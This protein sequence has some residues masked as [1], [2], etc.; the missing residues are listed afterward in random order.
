MDS[1]NM[2]INIFSYQCTISGNK[3]LI[4]YFCQQQKSVN[5]FYFSMLILKLLNISIYENIMQISLKYFM[6]HNV[7]TTF[8]LNNQNQYKYLIKEIF[9]TIDDYIKMFNLNLTNI[10][11]QIIVLVKSEISLKN[12]IVT[13]SMTCPVLLYFLRYLHFI[14]IF[15][16][17]SEIRKIKLFILLNI[18]IYVRFCCCTG[19]I[20]VR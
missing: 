9:S 12:F 13:L 2:F 3:I 7:Q 11:F 19:R 16:F 5:Y 1:K 18:Y 6:F 20:I 10:I 14:T 8:Y 4:F 17:V 15:S